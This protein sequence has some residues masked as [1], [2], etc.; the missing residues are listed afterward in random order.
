VA[1]TVIKVLEKVANNI[2]SETEMN[3]LLIKLLELFCKIGVRMKEN[4]EK[5]TKNTQK[6]KFLI[7]CIK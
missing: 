6:V 5:L 3:D 1:S 2:S 7:M 4:M